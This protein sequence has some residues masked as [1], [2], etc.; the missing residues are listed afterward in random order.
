MLYPQERTAIFI[1]GANYYDSLKMAKVKL[2]LAAF[3]SRLRERCCLVTVRYYTGVS[4][5]KKYE[6]I[7]RQLDWMANN[8]IV[9][10]TKPVKE[11]VVRDDETGEETKITKANV[12]VEMTVDIIRMSSRL[13]HVILFSGDG[14]FIPLVKA[15]QEMGVRVSC[16]ST[17]GMISSD[18]KRQVDHYY[19]FKD[20]GILGGA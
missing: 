12:D 11:F 6:D 2:D 1:D 10:V 8:D 16:V 4:S 15:V 3:M 13:D 18:L 9:L 19:D 7:K 17:Q 20:G 5:S 14:D